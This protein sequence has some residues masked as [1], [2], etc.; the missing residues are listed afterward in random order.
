MDSILSSFSGVGHWGWQVLGVMLVTA[1]LAVVLSSGLRLCQRFVSKSR[2]LWD[3]SLIEALEKPAKLWIWMVG[4]SFAVDLIDA[5]NETSWLTEHYDGFRRFCYI[6]LA[7]WFLFR[8]IGMV[9][10]HLSRPDLDRP[11]MD[12][13]T[14]RMLG[15]LIRIALSLSVILIC[16][17]YLGY[18]ISGLLTFG[19]V[20]GVVVGFAARE[21]I[22]N[23]FGGMMIHMDRPFREG[24][25][26]RSPDKEIEGTVEEIG[27]RMTRVRTFDKRPL[28]IPNASFMTISIENPSRMSNRRIKETIGVRYQ[29]VGRVDAILKEVR[30][31][32]LQHEAIDQGQTLMVNL[33]QFNASSVDFF[34]YCFTRTTVWSEFHQIKERVL[35]D[36]INII[37]RH[38]VDVAF[39]TRTVQVESL[40]EPKVVASGATR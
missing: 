11:A 29:D 12:R 15:R 10:Q 13:S 16:M 36:I 9:E 14:V 25:W 2:T 32:L 20:G 37:H 28:Y 38:G 17:Q 18:N 3:D 22:A 30:N 24:D 21:T 7:A 27:W 8:F 31:Y 39:P 33:N 6:L 34:I 35:L 23:F 40:P 19:G 4:I 5:A 1:T 26:V